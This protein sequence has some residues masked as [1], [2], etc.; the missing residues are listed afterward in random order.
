MALEDLSVELNHH[1]TGGNRGGGGGAWDVGAG[2]VSHAIVTV[3]SPMMRK[4]FAYATEISTTRRRCTTTPPH[5]RFDSQFSARARPVGTH[6]RTTHRSTHRSAV[7]PREAEHRAV[8]LDRERAKVD[9]RDGHGDRDKIGR[10]EPTETVILE[11][12]HGFPEIAVVAGTHAEIWFESDTHKRRAPGPRARAHRQPGRS[13]RVTECEGGGM[14][15][16]V[17]K[18]RHRRMITGDEER[19][20]HRCRAM[21]VARLSRGGGYLTAAD[22]GAGQGVSASGGSDISPGAPSSYLGRPRGENRT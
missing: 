13:Q 12:R 7:I 8:R 4:T 5:A 17:G 11:A 18:V 19:L 16:G 9:G 20:F 15:G 3:R 1:L 22:W 2:G 6:P 10:I 21:Q 14:G